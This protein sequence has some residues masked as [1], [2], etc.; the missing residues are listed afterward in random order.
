MIKFLETPCFDSKLLPF[1]LF[2][3]CSSPF[4]LSSLCFSFFWPSLFVSS[5]FTSFPFSDVCYEHS[6]SF[7]P[8]S[9]PHVVMKKN[10]LIDVEKMMIGMSKTSNLIRRFAK[11]IKGNFFLKKCLQFLIFFLL[12]CGIKNVFPL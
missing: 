11:M 6:P 7:P 3:V 8:L 9:S 2:S 4:E 12:S 10:L 1:N 5:L